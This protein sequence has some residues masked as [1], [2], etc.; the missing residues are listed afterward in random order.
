MNPAI[1]TAVALTVGAATA[2]A[3]TTTLGAVRERGTLNCGVNPG[4]PGFSQSDDKGNWRGFDVDYC[5][6]IAAAVLGDPARTHY[7]P[8]SA[9][10]RFSLLKSGAIDVLVRNTTWTST[11]D[12]ALGLSFVGASYYDGQGFMVKAALGKTS[13]RD[14]DGATVCVL[15]ATTTELNLTS[16]FKASNMTIKPLAFDKLEETVQAYLAER[17]QAYSADMS[18]LYS[19]RVQQARPKD[20]VVLPET[21][22]K[23]PLGPSVRQGDFQ[24]F[25][26]VR[27]VHFA[28]LGAEELGVTKANIND[29]AQSANPDVKRLLGSEAEFGAGLGLDN[30]FAVKVIRAVGNYGEIYERNL[31]SQSRL[32]IARGLNNLWNKGGLQ[33]APPVR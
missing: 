8:A 4:L 3:Q 17:C 11:R 18:S 32:K 16:Y 5:K 6:A 19:V 14:L 30:D 1:A 28:L 29:M 9:R 12:S 23:E 21:I 24:W 7:V 20:H 15:G 2:A 13:V 31:G 25:T 27:W 22:S 26:I 10:E 33:Y